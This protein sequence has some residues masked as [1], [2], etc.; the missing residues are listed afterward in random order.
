MNSLL[1]PFLI[2]IL[3]LAFCAC[4]L[5]LSGCSPDRAAQVPGELFNEYLAETSHPS[6]EEQGK[7]FAAVTMEDLDISVDMASATFVSAAEGGITVHGVGAVP[8]QGMLTIDR[9]GT[10]VLSGEMAGQLQVDTGGAGLVRIVLDNFTLSGKGETPFL[11][12]Q[13]GKLLLILKEGTQNN[14]IYAVETAAAAEFD[15]AAGAAGG[16]APDEPVAAVSPPGAALLVSAP[17]TI[18]GSGALSIESAGGSGLHAAESLV[19]AG[20]SLTV[21]AG[22][23]ALY[24][25]DGVAFLD[26]TVALTAGGNGLTTGADAQGGIIFSGG[27]CLIRAAENGLQTPRAVAMVNGRLRIDAARSGVEAGEG[28]L[29]FNSELIASGGPVETGAQLGQHEELSQPALLITFE[30][31]REA[32]STVEL[33]SGEGVPLAVLQPSFAYR[34]IVVSSP[35]LTVGQPVTIALNGA[36]LARITMEETE[37][38][39]QLP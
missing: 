22:A 28:V 27:S 8:E 14:I 1:K 31:E 15:P 6:G 20:T 36:E 13:C 25:A 26:S 10:Y 29:L 9:P 4:L 39:L 35:A 2:P 11:A 5:E 3:P 33:R 32:F 16:I 23:T 21:T 38:L 7:S 17:L 12:E 18:N 30:E 37:Q 34:S 24:S 19:V